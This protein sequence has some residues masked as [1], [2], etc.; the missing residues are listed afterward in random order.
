MMTKR[1]FISIISLFVIVLAMF[2]LSIFKTLY[3]IAKVTPAYEQAGSGAKTLLVMGDSTGYGTG[4][5][6]RQ[7]T[8]AGRIGSAY[9]DLTITNNSVNGRT[10]IELVAAAKEVTS[11]NDVI[12]IQIGANDLLKGASPESVVATVESL[13]QILTPQ[14]KHII[15]LTSGNIGAAWRFEG[16]KATQLTAVSKKY[17][18]LMR[19]K[20]A[21]SDFEFIS[22]WTTPD[23]DPFVA[24][25]KTY[26]AFDGL[27]P[28]SAGY[29]VW[30]ANLQPVLAAA[31]A[32]DL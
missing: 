9:P 18:E 4:A 23:Q 29:G 15:V 27:H 13:V 3:L 28:S 8:L 24:E 1:T 20:A 10:A 11:E 31:L 25:P 21:V 30:F 6:T 22:L 16:E 17:D 19:E 5:A 7:E 32:T 12:L 2:Q 14:A 26:L